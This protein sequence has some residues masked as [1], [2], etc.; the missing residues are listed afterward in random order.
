MIEV[1]PQFSNFPR[2]AE[3]RMS[4]FLFLIDLFADLVS[5]G[6]KLKVTIVRDYSLY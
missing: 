2:K 3:D 4:D 6:D 5:S 1:K